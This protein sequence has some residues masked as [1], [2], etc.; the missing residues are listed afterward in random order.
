MFI[1]NQLVMT[2]EG[3]SLTSMLFVLQDL[4]LG[5][6]DNGWCEGVGVHITAETMIRRN[7]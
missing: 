7:K 3:S 1:E 2:E 6:W 5:D 4:G